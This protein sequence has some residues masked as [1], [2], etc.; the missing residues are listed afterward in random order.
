[1]V[2]THELIAHPAFPPMSARRV[3]ASLDQPEAGWIRLRWRIEGADRIVVPPFAGSRRKDGLWQATCGELFVAE[4]GETGAAGAY[5][6]FNFSPSEAWAAYRFAAYRTGD[7]NVQVGRPP[8]IAWRGRGQLALL[9][10]WLATDA[11]PPPPWPYGMT[12]VIAE[13]GG[14][15]SYWA[16]KHPGERPD[17]HDPACLAFN[18]AP[19]LPP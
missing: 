9:D 4:P 8:V 12:M 5:R 10:V 18:H 15:V 14:I 16:A 13:Q 17:F 2:Q 1:M 19:P 3:A 7:G 6:E 11:L